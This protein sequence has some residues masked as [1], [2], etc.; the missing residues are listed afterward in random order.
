MEIIVFFKV[1]HPTDESFFTSL[2]TYL[3]KNTSGCVS[4]IPQGVRIELATWGP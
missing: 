4:S 2:S 1:Y 3:Q